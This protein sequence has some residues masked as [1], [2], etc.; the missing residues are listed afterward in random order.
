MIADVG[1]DGVKMSVLAQRAGVPIGTV[2]QFFPNKS[3]VIHML[4]TQTMTQM[5]TTLTAQFHDVRSLEDAAERVEQA[6]RGI[7]GSTQGDKKLQALDQN[8][9]RCNSAMM[10]QQINHLVAPAD[11]DHL[12]ATLFLNAHLTGSMTRLAVMEDADMVERL[13][14]TFIKSVQRDLM[15]FTPAEA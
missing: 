6:V 7:L 4:V 11:H 9:S 3:A 1:S 8:D 5:R 10:F 13:Q 2:Y 15:M 12:R 14:H